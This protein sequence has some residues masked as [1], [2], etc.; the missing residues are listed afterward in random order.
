MKRQ[1]GSTKWWLFAIAYMTIW[2]YSLALII[3][4]LGGFIAGV[5]PFDLYTVVAIVVLATILLLL[6]R[7]ESK[8]KISIN[9]PTKIV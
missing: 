4:R 8:Q 5:L 7:K 1:L 2:S 6:F 3:F 9:I